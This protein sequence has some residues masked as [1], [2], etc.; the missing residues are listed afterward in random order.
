MVLYPLL[1]PKCCWFQ[2]CFGLQYLY[3]QLLFIRPLVSSCSSSVVSSAVLYISS[4]LDRTVVRVS[5]L[6]G[7]ASCKDCLFKDQIDSIFRLSNHLFFSRSADPTI[8]P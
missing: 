5:S 4:C 8:S 3:Q 7:E 1:E 6:L 2:Q